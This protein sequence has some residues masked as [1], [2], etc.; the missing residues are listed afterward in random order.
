MFILR[1]TL[2]LLFLP[3]LLPAFAQVQGP[4]A[5]PPTRAESAGAY[6]NSTDGLRAQ[7]QDIL[8]AAREPDHSHL[9][10][11]IKA[12]KMPNY[13]AWFI[14]NYGEER[15]RRLAN[16]YGPNLASF[17][18]DSESLFSQ[19]AADNG[20]L[21]V[22]AHG[23]ALRPAMDR[24]VRRRLAVGLKEFFSVQW[25]QRDDSGGR[26]VAAIGTFVYVDGQFRTLWSF[27]KLDFDSYPSLRAPGPQAGW[28]T[29]PDHAPNPDNSNRPVT[30]P[31]ESGV[32]ISSWPTCEYCP[33]AEYPEEARKKHLEGT[34]VLQVT[35]QPDGSG[36]D[37]KVVSSPEPEM[38]QAAMDTVGKWRFKPARNVDGDPVPYR[39]AIEVSFRM[40]K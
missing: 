22:N 14:E 7:L 3:V 18:S 9:E 20:E 17:V 30:G 38:A 11:L 6:D 33:G 37:I 28:S 19:I 39:E 36:T 15:G 16:S 35:V 34:V 26:R 32:R 31:V 13:E 21:D 1:R 5:P 4:I 24:G 25:V 8:A 23:V 40:P 10:S 27:A 12:L 2:V 29:S